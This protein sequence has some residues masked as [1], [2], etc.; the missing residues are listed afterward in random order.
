MKNFMGKGDVTINSFI[1]STEYYLNEIKGIALQKQATTCITYSKI[2]SES[3]I[4]VINIAESV[5]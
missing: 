3:K 5:D 2:Q 4:A 1:T